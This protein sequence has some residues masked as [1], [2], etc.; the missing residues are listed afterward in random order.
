MIALCTYRAPGGLF[1][2]CFH[3]DRTLVDSIHQRAGQMVRG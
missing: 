3:G 1:L 2:A